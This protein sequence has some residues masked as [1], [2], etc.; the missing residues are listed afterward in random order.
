MRRCLSVVCMVFLNY[1]F[2]YSNEE[3]IEIGD[4][5]PLYY[6]LNSLKKPMDSFGLHILPE[7]FSLKRGV[8]LALSIM[9][10][11]APVARGVYLVIFST[12]VQ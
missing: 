4:R 11:Q 1:S 6:T 8:F 9:M 5:N 7:N 10:R 12:S 2:W 3:S